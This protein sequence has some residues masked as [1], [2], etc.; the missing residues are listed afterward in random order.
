MTGE[1]KIMFSDNRRHKYKIEIKFIEEVECAD[2]SADL[3]YKSSQGYKDI[4]TFS[5]G[6]LNLEFYRKNS[7]NIENVFSTHKSIVYHQLLKSLVYYY[8]FLG[9]ANQI[10]EILIF[11]LINT[12]VLLKKKLKSSDINQV[13]DSS[14]ELKELALI[15]KDILKIIFSETEVGK[16]CLY[17]FTHLIKSYSINSAS[18]SFEKKWKSF[19]ALYRVIS[20]KTSEHLRLRFLREHMDSHPEQYPNINKAMNRLS[21]KR[22]RSLIRWNKFIQNDFPSSEKNVAKKFHDFILRNDDFRVLDIVKQSISL[23]EDHLNQANLLVS[24]NNH[25]NTRISAK[26]KNNMHL[27]ATICIKYMYFVRNKTFHA[28][29]F[30]SGFRLTLDNDEKI[31]TDWLSTM[32]TLMII[33][34]FNN[35]K[36]Y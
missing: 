4:L 27:A 18:D 3:P 36:S 20:Q 11:E 8:S 17:S 31:E 5:K 21:I 6:T 13:V 23:R 28:E 32:L 2:F 15:D 29:Q 35:I 26:T 10:K 12:N 7:L 1:S 33:D 14:A 24:V 16:A 34:I 9:H 25:I 22:I 30:D 19:N